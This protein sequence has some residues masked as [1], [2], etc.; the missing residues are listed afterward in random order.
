MTTTYVYTVCPGE[1][2]AEEEEEQRRDFYTETRFGPGLHI[3][4]IDE[5][6]TWRGRLAFCP[7]AA[8][9]SPLVTVHVCV[10]ILRRCLTDEAASSLLTL[11]FDQLGPPV[12]R[13]EGEKAVKKWMTWEDTKAA[14][15]Y[16]LI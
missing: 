13:R 3:K 9:P 16:D 4:Y 11:S 15:F 1:S 8:E 7:A 6:V 12:V 5:V 2:E 10:R 14:L